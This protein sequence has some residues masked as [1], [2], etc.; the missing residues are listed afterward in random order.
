MM[1]TIRCA[2]LGLSFAALAAAPAMAAGPLDGDWDGTMTAGAESYHMVLHVSSGP[3]GPA[4]VLDSL[5]QDITLTA[6]AVKLEDGKLS[7]L[8]LSVEGELEGRFSDDGKTFTGVW[9]Q[10]LALPIT[11]R[12]K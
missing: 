10:A 3:D 12:K 5:D 4:M 6:S 1:Q 11:L 9:K 2:A 8:F 7:A